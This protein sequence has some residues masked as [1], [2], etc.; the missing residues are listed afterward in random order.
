MC[1][2]QCQCAPDKPR[3]PPREKLP[4]DGS[5]LR[6]QSLTGKADQPYS[7]HVLSCGGT[8]GR[9]STWSSPRGL[10]L[11]SKSFRAFRLYVTSVSSGSSRASPTA[12]PRLLTSSC[13]RSAILP[14]CQR[15]EARG[16]P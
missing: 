12:R 4:V 13:D 2:P 3:S 8:M 5:A 11:S 9:G 16:G 7:C 1:R 10:T 15:Y 6:E 14:P